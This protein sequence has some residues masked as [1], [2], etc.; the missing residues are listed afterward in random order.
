MATSTAAA[1]PLGVLQVEE[2]LDGSLAA[3]HLHGLAVNH[4]G[5]ED[6]HELLRQW[7][8]RKHR[9][10]GQEHPLK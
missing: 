3:I 6:Q 8:K 5:G 1:M 10:L 2:K 7:L 4:S 9:P